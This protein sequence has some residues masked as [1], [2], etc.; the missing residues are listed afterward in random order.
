M[1]EILF[2]G[3]RVDNDEWI[4]GDLL[5]HNEQ[6]LIV[7][8]SNENLEDNFDENVQPETVGQFTGLKDKNGTKIFEGD[9]LRYNSGIAKVIYEDYMFMA[10]SEGS[11]AID[12][13]FIYEWNNCEI[14]GNIHD[15]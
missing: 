11:E 14:I 12:E 6:T 1:R 10:E 15:K 4:Y 5:Q 7:T 2:R 3:K 9:V 8:H 13:M